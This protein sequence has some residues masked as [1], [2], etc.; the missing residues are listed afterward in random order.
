VSAQSADRKNENL[1][2]QLARLANLVLGTWLVLSNFVWRHSLLEQTNAWF[3]GLLCFTFAV[4]AL[5]SPRARLLNRALSVWLFI[6]ALVFPS[7]NPIT[8]WNNAAIAIA[9][10]A[11]SLVPSGQQKPIRVPPLRPA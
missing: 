6:S 5:G 11:V 10:F 3:V 4:L 2:S 8:R 7:A 9:I 1:R